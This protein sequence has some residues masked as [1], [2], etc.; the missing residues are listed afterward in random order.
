MNRTVR[1]KGI[2]PPILP[3]LDAMRARLPDLG[4]SLHNAA[5]DLGRDLTLERVDEYMARLK[6]AQTN[7]THMRRALVQLD[8][9]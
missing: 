2:R 7:M 6:G 5:I 9:G 3:D 4:E 1:V 8:R